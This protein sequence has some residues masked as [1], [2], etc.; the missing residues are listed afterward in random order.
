VSEIFHGASRQDLHCVSDICE[1][2]REVVR[3]RE[4]KLA[5]RDP[6]MKRH[7]HPLRSRRARVNVG[8]DVLSS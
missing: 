3:R 1:P 6:S 4:L 2:R 7:D 8:D 5:F